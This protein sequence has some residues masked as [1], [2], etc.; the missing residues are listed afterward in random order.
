[1]SFAPGIT[2]RGAGL[3]RRQM[4]KKHL[5]A[6]TASVSFAGIFAI[7]GLGTSNAQEP[8]DSAA[9]VD[10]RASG[11]FPVEPQECTYFGPGRERFLPPAAR[12]NG[13]AAGRLTRQFM[14]LS[15]A[16]ISPAGR[17]RP[18]ARISGAGGGSEAPGGK[19]NLIDQFINSDLQANNITPADKTNDWEFIRRV[20]LDLTGRI[21][22]PD[23]VTQFVAST[24]PNKRAS[25]I[26]ELLAKPEWVDKWTMY[27]GDLFKNTAST[28]QIRIQPEGR[29]A[30]YK[31]I[32]DSLASHKPYDQMATELIS[33][34]GNNNFDQTNGQLNYLVLGVVT[35]GPAQDIFDSQTANVADQFLGI[36]HVNCLLCHNGNG[37]LNALSLWGSQT[38]R[39]QAWGLSAFMAHTWTRTLTLPPDP[40]KP[41]S[42][43][44]NYWSLDQYK[45]DY[46][47]NTTTGN[48][49]PRQPIGTLK[50]VTPTYLFSGQTA[51][52]GTDSRAELAK[53]VTS[54]F[55]FA[56]ASVNYIW[57][58]FFGAGIVDPP[59]QFDPARLDPNN[60]PPSP[61]TLQPS[62][63]ALLNALAQSFIDSG[64]DVQ[65]LMRL[66]ANS[67]TYQLASDYSG[68]WDPAW[69]Q[70]FG[71]KLVRRLWSEEIHDS[72][73]TAINT[74]PS[75][76][77][78]GFTNASAVYGVDSP[79]FGKISYAMQ[80]P[81]VVNMPDGGGGVSQ[82]LDN[83]LRGNRDD[84]PRKG[85]GSILQAL[86]LMNDNF[87]ESRIHATGNTSTGSYLEKLRPLSDSQLVNTLF[88][89]VLSR[90]PSAK[91]LSQATAEIGAGGL[92]GR[93]KAAEDLLWTLFNKVDFTFNY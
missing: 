82:F 93:P 40:S 22:T 87:V 68:T 66:I 46:A 29:N 28:V 34:Q 50:V 43:A 67:D 53:F 89:D 60:P 17:T 11:T 64:Y 6:F 71:R 16:R 92:A 55:Q 8:A 32:H 70:Y 7:Y 24:D 41:N 62:N 58:Q 39:L 77:V 27:Y 83:F 59:D 4:N 80:A 5:A 15:G 88:L 10:A 35:G 30:F 45:T 86:A 23:R 42:R 57:A 3:F 19:G 78:P 37:H 51:P 65:A 49:P 9:A 44:Y 56:R 61:W 36:A 18:F 12:K 33:A 69:D 84:Q 47:L 14:S 26:D 52:K 38:T 90:Q 48:R 79:G 20:T 76:T 91:E 2:S 1:M 21:P 31:W 63:A 81:D 75:Y 13:L 25:L 72:M 54:D 73:V 74:L 85:E